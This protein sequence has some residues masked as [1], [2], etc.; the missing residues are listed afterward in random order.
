LAEETYINILVQLTNLFIC[1]PTSLINLMSIFRKQAIFL[2][3]LKDEILC[4]LVFL[5]G[6][7]LLLQTNPCLFLEL[8]KSTSK[9]RFVR[10]F[11]MALWEGPD[12]PSSPFDQEYFILWADTDTPT[13]F[14]VKRLVRAPCA[15]VL[16]SVEHGVCA[17][18]VLY[19]VQAHRSIFE[20]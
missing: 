16:R 5:E 6:N 8:S 2:W 11:I 1:K 4:C 3:N 9:G 14:V 10:L 19:L 15:P 18:V 7:I 17:R 13:D 12:L 20:A